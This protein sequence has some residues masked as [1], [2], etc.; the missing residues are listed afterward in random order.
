MSIEPYPIK[1]DC[2]REVRER[3]AKTKE[4]LDEI[5]RTDN[6]D[7]TDGLLKIDQLEKSVSVDGVKIT[8]MARNLE[9]IRD[10]YGVYGT[11]G[12]GLNEVIEFLRGLL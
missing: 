3:N 11:N 1:T 5:F 8:R 6:D 12:D 2:Y 7:I 10:Y 4:L 9:S